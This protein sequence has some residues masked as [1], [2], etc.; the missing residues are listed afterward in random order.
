MQKV[1]PANR[2]SRR[3]PTIGGGG[4]WIVK[5]PIHFHCVL[6]TL[7]KEELGGGPNST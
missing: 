3:G 5:P 2:A 4:G 1:K 7:E 6:H